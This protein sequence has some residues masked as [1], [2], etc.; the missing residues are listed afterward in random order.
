MKLRQGVVIRIKGDVLYTT[1]PC[2]VEI[3]TKPDYLQENAFSFNESYAH[4][5]LSISLIEGKYHQ[6]RKM[7]A[8][9]HHPVKRLIRTSIENISV[10]KLIPGEVVEME[11]IEFFKKLRINNY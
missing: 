2:D 8:S 6:V 7:L 11:E 10:E 4:T 9:V 3:V 5:W 1:L